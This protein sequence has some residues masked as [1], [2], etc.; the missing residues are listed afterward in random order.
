MSGMQTSMR[1][2]VEII[3]VC[4]YLNEAI[5]DGKHAPQLLLFP[6]ACAADVVNL[7]PFSLNAQ[8]PKI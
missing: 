4:F 2:Y 7:S 3:V 5:V 6:E 1:T 8:I